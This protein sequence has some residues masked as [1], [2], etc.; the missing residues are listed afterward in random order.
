LP[1]IVKWDK[2]DFVG[3]PSLVRLRRGESEE[4]GE[5]QRLVGFAV[6]DRSLS[7]PE[8]CQ[9]VEEGQP[10]GRVTSFRQS[11]TL[12]R[13]I[14]LAWVPDAAAREGARIRIAALEGTVPATVTLKPFYDPEGLRVRG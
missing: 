1:W 4:N 5:R 7:I 14:G 10:V 8:G 13:G 2:E 3:R 9:V 11:P 12:G 6:S